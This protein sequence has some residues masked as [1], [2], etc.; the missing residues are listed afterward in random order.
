MTTIASL[1][2]GTTRR[3]RSRPRHSPRGAQAQRVP[4]AAPTFAIFASGTRRVRDRRGAPVGGAG[5]EAI[6]SPRGHETRA[7]ERG[8][9]HLLLL[10]ARRPRGEVRATD[11]RAEGEHGHRHRVPRRR[12]RHPRRRRRPAW[13]SSSTSST[14]STTTSSNDA[15]VAGHPPVRTGRSGVGMRGTNRA[16]IRRKSRAAS[17]ALCSAR[18]AQR[19]SRDGESPG[20]AL[21]RRREDQGT[22]QRSEADRGEPGWSA[23]GRSSSRTPCLR[24]G[25][26]YRRSAK[27]RSAESPTSRFTSGSSCPGRSGRC[28]PSD[29]PR[30]SW[31]TC[32]SR[33]SSRRGRRRCRSEARE[34]F[35]QQQGGM[36]G[37]HAGEWAG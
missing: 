27:P 34:R 35:A 37:E 9:G 7:G 14:S 12:Q 16:T 26:R 19:G 20:G 30:R 8:R 1:A 24:C 18:R 10:R 17:T 3:C 11:G 31:S 15:S 21:G 6:A 22:D 25:R 36:P 33:S 13:R 2:A 5:P 32:C 29:S 28:C 23:R 4:R